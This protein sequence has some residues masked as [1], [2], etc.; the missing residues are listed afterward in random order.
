MSNEKTA[1]DPEHET[2][3][4]RA[5]TG[6][7]VRLEHL[8]KRFESVIA[9]DDMTLSI[10][11]GEFITLLGPSGSGKTTTLMLIA[12]FEEPVGGEIYIDNQPIVAVPSFRRN[13]GMVFQNY[14]LFPHMTVAQNIAFPLKQR[15]IDRREIDR[16]VDEILGVVSLPGFGGRY[17]RQL[18]GGQQQR[19]AL[20]RAI[21]FKPRVLLMDE[22]LGALDKKLRETL[23]LEIRR[24]H[25][26]LGITFIHVTHD[27]EEALVMSDRIAVMNEGRV[28]QVGTP[29]DLYDRPNSRFVASF[30]GESNFLDGVVTGEGGGWNEV[31]IGSQ[32]L[33]SATGM[34]VQPGSRVTLAIRPEKIG[35]REE[36]DIAIDS[37][38]NRLPAEVREVTFAGEMRRYLLEIGDGHPM[39]VR[40]P[41]RHGIPL[42]RPGDRIE[43][44]WHIEDTRIV[45]L[46]QT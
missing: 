25:R 39:M 9:V 26:E 30:I 46:D 12:G 3:R 15:K 27:Q 19:V 22:P 42:H 38:V 20:A 21:V 5:A 41:L 31:Q 18:S 24:L 29:V 7:A 2:L 36:G 40:Q 1:A 6:A 43:L 4:R 14:A 11:P 13:I 10:E 35:F 33:R 17:P 16:R 23:Q 32:L 37:H 44:V 8:S 28:E 34:D 45:A